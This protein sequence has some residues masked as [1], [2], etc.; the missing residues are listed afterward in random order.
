M[1]EGMKERAKE[2]AKNLKLDNIPL[3]VI[4]KNTGLSIEIIETL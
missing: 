1:K 3:E 4:S 2:I